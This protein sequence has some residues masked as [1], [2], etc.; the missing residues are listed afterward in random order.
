[1]NRR[2]IVATGA[3]VA[4]VIAAGVII[5]RERSREEWAAPGWYRKRGLKAALSHRFPRVNA[6]YCMARGGTVAYRLR[7]ENGGI[8][9]DN[10]RPSSFIQ[11]HVT[12]IPQV[13]PEQAVEA[14]WER[15]EQDLADWDLAGSTA[16]GEARGLAVEVLGKLLP[17]AGAGV[18]MPMPGS[19][20]TGA[21]P[22]A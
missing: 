9:V 14:I 4:A 1:M 7:I 8:V 12:G 15:W 18:T 17:P 19:P 10:P 22:Q 5:A 11:V 6:A 13:G 2:V 16:N 20:G 21:S 3:G